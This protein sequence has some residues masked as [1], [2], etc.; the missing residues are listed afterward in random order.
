MSTR[1]ARQ[2]VQ[3]GDCH[4]VAGTQVIEHSGQLHPVEP[5]AGDFL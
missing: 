1:A 2:A 4:H 5:D 3:P